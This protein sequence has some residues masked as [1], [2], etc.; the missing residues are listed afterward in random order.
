MSEPLARIAYE[1]TQDDLIA[2]S[3]YHF[4]YASGPRRRRKM[5]IGFLAVYLF[6][7]N[8]LMYGL[9][10]LGAVL[11]NTFCYFFGILALAFILRRATGDR[12]LRRMYTAEKNR[13]FIGP[14]ELEV[15]DEGLTYRTAYQEG[16]MAWGMIERIESTTDHTF[17]YFGTASAIVI[18]HNGITQGEY[19]AFLRELG[20]R[21]K[22]DQPLLRSGMSA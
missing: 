4:Y 22:P 11:L 20:Q 3:K 12:L 16:K 2:Y 19:R 9:A 8:L 5:A 18:P 13:S 10:N 21:F 7:V 1:A 6:G 15:T 14:H 17:I